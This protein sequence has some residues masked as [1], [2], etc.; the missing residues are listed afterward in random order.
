M[1]IQL[2]IDRHANLPRSVRDTYKRYKTDQEGV[3]NNE[4]QLSKVPKSGYANDN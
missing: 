1:R 4:Q 3:D 2:P